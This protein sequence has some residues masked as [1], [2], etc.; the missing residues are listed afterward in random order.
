[1]E[2]PISTVKIIKITDTISNL[3]FQR[4]HIIYDHKNKYMMYNILYF[5]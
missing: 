1:M 5:I 3:I 2:M 4:K